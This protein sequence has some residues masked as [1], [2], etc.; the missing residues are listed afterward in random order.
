MGQHLI[1]NKHPPPYPRPHSGWYQV[2]APLHPLDTQHESR[3]VTAAEIPAELFDFLLAHI[4]LNYGKSLLVTRDQKRVLGTCSLVCRYWASKCRANIFR[5]I[6]LR[7][8]Q[9]AIHIIEFLDAPTSCIAQLIRLVSISPQNVVDAPWFHLLPCIATR[10]KGHLPFS[11][12]LEGPL[13]GGQKSLR[14]IHHALPR[15]FP[16]LSHHIQD[17]SVANMRFA[18]LDDIMH[19]VWEMTSLSRLQCFGV[20]WGSMPA[21]LPARKPANTAYWP[22]I[23]MEQCDPRSTEACVWISACVR[24]PDSFFSLD[25]FATVLALS[26]AIDSSF[27]GDYDIERRIK[28]GPFSCRKCRLKFLVHISKHR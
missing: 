11:I 19:L 8:R 3:P 20:T 24:R 21:A 28:T 23:R 27:T 6:E 25:D 5:Q 4:T 16:H 1:S 12:S 18:R 15:S 7:S 14:S 17:L 10:L 2:R 13:P 26:R 9:D 22:D